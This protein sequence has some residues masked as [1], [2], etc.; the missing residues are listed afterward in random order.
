[1]VQVKDFID[2]PIVVPAES[3]DRGVQLERWWAHPIGAATERIAE[4][5]MNKPPSLQKYLA[6]WRANHHCAVKLVPGVAPLPWP[7]VTQRTLR[8]SCESGEIFIM[9]VVRLAGGIVEFHVD[10]RAT[11]GDEIDLRAALVA[12]LARVERPNV[13]SG[14]GGDDR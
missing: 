14:D 8:G 4:L 5:R 13:P 12:P 10:H 3:L 11:V 9:H 1:M 7:G 6:D 2:A